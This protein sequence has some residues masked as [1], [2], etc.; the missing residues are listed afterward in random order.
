MNIVLME[1][2][3]NNDCEVA[4]IG[5]AC[6]VSYDKAESALGRIIFDLPD[7]PE[8]LIFANPWNLYRAIARLGFWKR[9]LTWEKLNDGSP[10]PG[11]VVI[12]VK[13]SLTS[14]HWIVWDGIQL[15]GNE[16]YHRVYWGNSTTPKLIKPNDLKEMVFRPTKPVT[17]NC[18]FEVY[19]EKWYKVLFYRIL[20]WFKT[21]F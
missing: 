17:V 7:A 4:V 19:P 2:P 3:D 11:K 10:E 18:I 8:S 21:Y 9:N 13:R 20:S 1:R 12:L 5:T 14:Q 6:Q 15:I 16:K